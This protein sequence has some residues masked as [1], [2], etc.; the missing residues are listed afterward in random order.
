MV[1][2]LSDQLSYTQNDLRKFFGVDKISFVEPEVKEKKFGF[3]V[4]HNETIGGKGKIDV[5]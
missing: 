5:F 4:R 3:K 1:F 2:P